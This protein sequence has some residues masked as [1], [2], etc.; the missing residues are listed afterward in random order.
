MRPGQG[1]TDYTSFFL[2]TTLTATGFSSWQTYLPITFL[3]LSFC[4][5]Q[6]SLRWDRYNSILS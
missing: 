3:L 6:I 2:L 4:N 1:R 5:A